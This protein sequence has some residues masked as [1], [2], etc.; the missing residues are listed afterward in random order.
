MIEE[1]GV[2]NRIGI[3]L[4]A[5]SSV[6]VGINEREKVLNSANNCLL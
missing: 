4:A 6:T 1:V 2:L 3:D 5:D